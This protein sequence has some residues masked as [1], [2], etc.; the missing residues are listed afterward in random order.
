[1]R[2]GGTAFGGI[3]MAGEFCGFPRS[4]AATPR[5]A[6]RAM[7]SR[8]PWTARWGVSTPPPP[9]FCAVP[10]YIRVY[11]SRVCKSVPPWGCSGYWQVFHLAPCPPYPVSFFSFFGMGIPQW[12]PDRART[13]S[14]GLVGVDGVLQDLR[15]RAEDPHAGGRH[16]RAERRRCLERGSRG[17]RSRGRGR[18]NKGTFVLC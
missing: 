3:G 10:W 2:T 12:E 11:G 14:Q 13:A 6:P 15:R 1:V 5:K 18:R 16:G 17:V 8:V 4:G 9:P 7:R